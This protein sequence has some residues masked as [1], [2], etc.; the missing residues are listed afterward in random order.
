LKLGPPEH[1]AGMIIAGPELAFRSVPLRE[2]NVLVCVVLKRTD[3]K[4]SNVCGSFDRSPL[5]N[6]Q[7]ELKL[8][9]LK[10]KLTCGVLDSGLQSSGHQEIPVVSKTILYSTGH[11]ELF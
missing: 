8:G 2:L 5:N 7:N 11:V 10:S 3:N 6:T 1:K 9:I 4:A